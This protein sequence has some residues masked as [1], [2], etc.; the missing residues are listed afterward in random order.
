MKWN[1]LLGVVG[2]EPVFASSLLRAGRASSALVRLQLARWVKSGR[3]IRLRR[4]LYVLAPPYRKVEPH[5]FV[6]ANSLRKNSYVSLQSALA[7][8][9]LI[10]EYVPM[11]TSVTTA[12]PEQLRTELGAY[13][14]KHIR[15]EF[16][17]GYRSVELSL[18]QRAFLATPEK[19]LLDLVYLTPGAQA[20]EYVR[21]LR[22]QNVE[23]I[24]STVLSEFARRMGKPKLARAARRVIGI[25]DE[26]GYEAL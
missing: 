4:G 23:T 1:E 11:V 20:E 9:G 19:A 24:D 6:V 15:R 18:N 21:G 16:F 3:I 7:H 10:P 14:F 13:T 22:L 2:R 5:P 12:R 8:H 17:F 25:L 26:R